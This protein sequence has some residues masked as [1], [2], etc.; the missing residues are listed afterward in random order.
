MLL[1]INDNFTF[2]SLTFDKSKD[3]PFALIQGEGCE[4]FFFFVYFT[5]NN[6]WF[7]QN[8]FFKKK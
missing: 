4:E 1:L 5:A 8:F 6:A 7:L 2:N 3:F